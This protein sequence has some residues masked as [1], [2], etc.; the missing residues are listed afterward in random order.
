[1]TL[2]L[3][4]KAERHRLAWTNEPPRWQFA[5]GGGLLVVAPPKADYYQDPAGIHIVSSAPFLHAAAGSDFALTTRLGAE[6]KH[7][8]DSGCL[9][10]LADDRNWAKLCFEYDGRRPIIVSVVT[11]DGSSDDCNS[12]PVGVERPYLRMT[13]AGDC[14]SFHW[15]ADGEAWTLVRYFGMRLPDACRAGVVAQ[16]PQ[17]TGCAAAFDFLALTEPGGGS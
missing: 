5:E 4:G 8:Y 14:V 9:M 17:G 3:F 1:M 7:R 13:R 11:K 12:E 2:Q 16:S 15:S 6:M 10:L